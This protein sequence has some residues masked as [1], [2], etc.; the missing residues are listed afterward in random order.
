[1]TPFFIV[2]PTATGKSEIAAELAEALNAEIVSADAFQI[3]CGIDRLTAKPDAATL[4]KA[5]HHLLGVIPFTEEMNVERFRIAAVTAIREIL[6]RGKNAIVVGGSGLYV[7]ALTDGLS[8]MPSADPTLRAKLSEFSLDQLCEQLFKL[9]PV[10]TRKID[11]KNRR[12][13]A[14]AVEI[15]L[16]TGKPLSQ[17]RSRDDEL[18]VD[19]SL[20]PN[21]PPPKGLFVF[22][23]RPDLYQ[24]INRRVEEMFVQGVVNEVR[25]LGNL[26]S[27][28]D[29]AIGLR[30]IRALLSGQISEVECV[31]RIQQ[32]TRRYAKRQLTWFQR[33]SKFE[34]LNLSSYGTP[35]AMELI[36][37][38][39]RSAFAQNDD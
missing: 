14:R 35:E 13:V 19:R 32:A 28:A 16:L 20:F 24:R 11:L 33:Q 29:K 7:R 23:D 1:M 27:T 34:P 5:R 9:D 18:D 22:R 4:A 3:Y 21:G 38:S 10:G 6:G 30:E 2:G 26:S 37:Q 31:A 12:R 39:A 25:V 8:R 36:A 15:C 17:V